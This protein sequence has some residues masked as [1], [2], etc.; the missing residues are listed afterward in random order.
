MR[1]CY[2]TIYL[3]TRTGDLAT[4][5]CARH[6]QDSSSSPAPRHSRPGWTRGER[7]P[8]ALLYMMCCSVWSQPSTPARAAS[9]APTA[10]ANGERA[11]EHGRVAH[12]GP[13]DAVAGTCPVVALPPLSA[14][15]RTA[16]QDSLATPPTPTD[17]AAA[18]IVGGLGTV[19]GA[20]CVP[21]GSHRGRWR[22]PLAAKRQRRAR[23]SC[24]GA[25]E[26]EGRGVGHELNGAHEGPPSP[27]PPP[28]SCIPRELGYC[29]RPPPLCSACEPC[30][31]SVMHRN[32]L[33][34]RSPLTP[35]A[36]PVKPPCEDLLEH[37]GVICRVGRTAGTTD[38]TRAER[39]TDQS[40]T[41]PPRSTSHRASRPR[42]PR[43]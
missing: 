27:I 33:S 18:Q 32:S 17:V 29:R 42:L 37:T 19:A 16:C 2:Y 36:T 28:R 12:R 10:V 15:Q 41:N 35:P 1:N 5:E 26:S 3:F 31:F 34:C 43:G 8:E 14:P 39:L 25:D 38:R 23:L 4:L 21:P 40:T 13:A 6:Q 30:F 22:C 7:W 9:T 11:D 24:G 20:L